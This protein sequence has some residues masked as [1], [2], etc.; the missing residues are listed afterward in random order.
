MPLSY[1]KRV[2]GSD[3]VPQVAYPQKPPTFM[4]RFV[5]E[6]PKH[7]NGGFINA[8]FGTVVLSEDETIVCVLTHS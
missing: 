6:T 1:R 5:L 4:D 7:F 8:E 3:P 2:P